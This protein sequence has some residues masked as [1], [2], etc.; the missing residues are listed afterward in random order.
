MFI[1][2]KEIQQAFALINFKM[3][4]IISKRLLTNDWRQIYARIAFKTVM[5]FKTFILLV[6]HLLNIVKEFKNLRKLII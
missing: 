2:N 3:E 4:K 6:D 1:D 5:C